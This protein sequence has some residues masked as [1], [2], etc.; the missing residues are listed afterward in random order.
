MLSNFK[1]VI[2]DNLY[3]KDP[4]SS[5]I[6]RKIIDKSYFNIKYRMNKDGYCIIDLA[7]KN[8]NKRIT[9]SIHR[10][11]ANVY[12]C[13]PFKDSNLPLVINHIDKNRDNNYYKNLEWVTAKGNSMHS[14]AKKVKQLDLKTGKT[15]KNF[16]SIK[17]AA[18]FLNS[19][20]SAGNIT[21]VCKNIS[22][23]CKGYGWK[24]IE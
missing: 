7:I 8:K 24:Y 9:I 15:I 18:E 23:S 5:E 1:V 22:K 11:V 16:N 21:R 13:N 3:L 10:L 2:S 12:C 6:G 19:P 4:E 20:G 14:I 17:E